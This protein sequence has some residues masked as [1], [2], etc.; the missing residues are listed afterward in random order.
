MGARK[1][2]GSAYLDADGLA[3]DGIPPGLFFT[4]GMCS[5]FLRLVDDGVIVYDQNDLYRQ[6]GRYGMLL[7][8]GSDPQD[9]DDLVVL[10]ANSQDS[11]KL[12]VQGNGSGSASEDLV[13]FATY[14][15][16]V[17]VRTFGKVFLDTR[18][19]DASTHR[20]LGE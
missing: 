13:R 8:S 7:R 15:E 10:D 19:A 2:L 18:D 17:A 6:F 9:P 11:T 5:E 3:P 4:E 1:L 20:I 12:L 14:P 16:N